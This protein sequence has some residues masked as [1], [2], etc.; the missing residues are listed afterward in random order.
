MS[1]SIAKITPAVVYI[2]DNDDGMSVTN[3]A[4]RVCEQLAVQYPGKR[5]V[6]R[7]TEGQWDELVHQNGR[8]LDFKFLDEK[9]I[10]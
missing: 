8:F 6:Y 2:I 5:I 1:Y 3:S 7:D 4:E 10:L 9:V